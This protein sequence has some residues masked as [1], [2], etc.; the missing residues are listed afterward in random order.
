MFTELVESNSHQK[1]LRRRF[2]FLIIT[3][4]SHVIFFAVISV[5]SISAYERQLEG[6]NVEGLLLMVPF[7]RPLILQPH[8]SI[9]QHDTIRPKIIIDTVRFVPPHFFKRDLRPSERLT[10]ANQLPLP[11][12]SI[13][14]DPTF[15]G[16]ENGVP[17]V[18]APDPIGTYLPEKSVVNFAQEPPP[19]ALPSPAPIIDIRVSSI[20]NSN[21]MLVPKPSYPLL[22]IKAR[23][24]GAVKIQIVIDETGAVISATAISGNPVLVPDSVR[25]ATMARFAPTIVNGKSAKVTGVLLYN[26]VL[27]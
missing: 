13:I 22:A 6:E 10:I 21:A 25:A 3:T 8:R 9:Y 16:L 11:T 27:Q 23:I 5:I 7:E 24:K 14:S 26:F 15:G 20:V 17:E 19:L 4:V 12:T 1:E 2:S 18:V